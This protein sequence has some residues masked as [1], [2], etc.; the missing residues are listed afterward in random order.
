MQACLL[1]HSLSIW[2]PRSSTT[3][4]GTREKHRK[5]ELNFWW[6]DY[7]EKHLTS[8][9]ENALLGSHAIPYGSPV[10]PARHVQIPLWFLA[11]QSA[12]LAHLQG[13]TH[14]SFWHARVVGHSGSVRHS[15]CLQRIYGSGSGLYPGGQEQTALWF[16]AEQSAFTP[17][18]SNG[19]GSTHSRLRQVCVRG[20][21]E[22]LLQ[23]AI[24]NKETCIKTI[25]IEQRTF[26]FQIVWRSY[27]LHK[28][29][30]DLQHSPLDRHKLLDDC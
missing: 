25:C 18:L 22:S 7:I 8:Y 24:R 21:S 14:C 16:F 26:E 12:F 5:L 3:G 17:H 15:Y 1:G 23:P 6:S 30:M 11:E 13:S 28:C 9:R 10:N 4:S 29:C 19:H 27:V 2:Q 20:H